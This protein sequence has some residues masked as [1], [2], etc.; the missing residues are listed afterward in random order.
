MSEQLQPGAT[1]LGQYTIERHVASGGM[2]AVY[3]A[4]DGVTGREVAIKVMLANQDSE[5][6]LREAQHQAGLAH[7]AIVPIHQATTDPVTGDLAIVMPLMAGS[8]QDQ[9]P[10]CSLEDVVRWL[11]PVAEGL[12]FLH[13]QG[14]IHRDLKPHNLLIKPDGGVQIADFGLLKDLDEGSTASGFI[15]TER[16]MA[17]EQWRKGKI[18]ATTDIYA[19]GL[20]AYRL[21]TAQLPFL[22]PADCTTK[23]PIRPRRYM[24][25]IPA[26]VEAALLKA[27][28]RSPAHRWQRAGDFL[29]ELRSSLEQPTIA[30]PPLPDAA[31]G[32]GRGMLGAPPTLVPASTIIMVVNRYL[33]LV[34]VALRRGNATEHTFRPLLLD[35]LQACAPG[36]VAVNEPRRIACGAPDIQMESDGIPLGH[37]EAKAPGIDLAGIVSDSERTPARTTSGRQLARYRESLPNLLFTDGLLWHWFLGGA[38]RPPAPVRLATWDGT[39]LARDPRAIDDF[40]GLLTA[41]LAGQIPSISAPN[42]L[43]TRLARLA[44]L[45]DQAVREA[46]ATSLP[47]ADL[48]LQ[49]NALREYLLPDLTDQDFADLYAQTITY[50]LFTA[51]VL[52]PTTPFTLQQ[53]AYLIPDTIPFLRRLFSEVA[54]PSLDAGVA[55]IV[56]EIVRLLAATDMGIVLRRFGQATR[57]RD[58]IFHFYETFLAAYN[59]GLRERLGI[60]YTPQPVVD[61]LVRAVDHLLRQ[62][63]GKGDGLAD[64]SVILLDPATGTATFPYTVVRHIHEQVTAQMG[65]GA[66]AQYVGPK[67][68]PRVFAFELLMAPYAIAHLKLLLFLAEL[69]YQPQG[70]ERLGIYLTNTLADA[71]HLG[72]LLPG[73]GAALTREAQAA[74][75]VK[76]RASVMVVLGNPPYSGHSRNT[77]TWITGLVEDYKSVAGQPLA[78]RNTK[79]LQDDYVKFIRFAQW[80]IEQTGRGIV[81]YITNNGYL[82]NPTFR[83]MRHSLLTSFDDI[84][85]LNLHGNIDKGEHA[86]DGEPDQN[87]FDIRLGVAIVL[88]VR[89]RARPEGGAPATLAIVHYADLWG[90]RASKYAALSAQDMAT[91]PWQTVAPLAPDY[92]FI[93]QELAARAEFDL[94]ASV[95]KA[96]PFYRTG[97]NTH[98]DDFAIAIDRATLESRIE[99][100]LDPA[101]DAAAAARRFN[102]RETRDFSVAGARAALEALTD[103]RAAIIPCLYRPFDVRQLLYVPAILDRARPDLNRQMR[104]PNLA[105]VTTR[106]TRE[107]FAALATDLVCGQHKIAALY[108][109]SSIFPLYLYPD[110]ERPGLLDTTAPGG[111]RSNLDLE[112]IG[113]MATALGLTFVD[114]GRGDAVSTFGPE[115]VFHYYYL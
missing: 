53:A 74:D 104:Q 47:A 8:L 34:E 78:E 36:L 61:Y 9:A 52:A 84:Y 88:F 105:L 59:P 62:D 70:Q 27:L 90:D 79:W 64:E 29:A 99:A 32:A 15:G 85:I 2:G 82:D 31:A 71:P 38:A 109:G 76:H 66:W 41:V 91:T 50:G 111:R 56:D 63:F 25:S 4:R 26:R 11:T 39:Y 113:E 114:D 35:L 57:R 6:F 86:P 110:P 72:Q 77:G 87:V 3:A 10:P 96:F 75:E 49:R 1:L 13:S 20:I 93:P 5:A 37:V 7:P 19:L 55:W 89:H 95:A 28:E 42:D 115:D 45:L 21:L 100:F 22:A 102:L 80:R 51:R 24:P 58:P 18:R 94:G 16:Y 33:D 23:A 98:R 107:P 43:A 48:P 101:L 54:G 40:S 112:L 81:A 92:R 73:F 106:Q 67:L 83:G 68:L 60:Y 12:D 30:T 46:L 108:D 69:G 44:R 97:M 103:W 14:Y 17:P 65:A